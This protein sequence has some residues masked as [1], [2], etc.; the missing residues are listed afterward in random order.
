[1][2][3]VPINPMSPA[4]K[5]K[6]KP[7]KPH[8]FY[9]FTNSP[10]E[11]NPNHDKLSYFMREQLLSWIGPQ[12]SECCDVFVRFTN[13][14]ECGGVYPI[15]LDEKSTKKHKRF[16]L[17]YECESRLYFNVNNKTPEL[18]EYNINNSIIAPKTYVD[19]IIFS[20][21]NVRFSVTH[22]IHAFAQAG[23]RPCVVYWGK[24]DKDTRVIVPPYIA[25]PKW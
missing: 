22:G 24:F 21:S 8:K 17:T 13:Y 12:S 1:M 6:H 18:V 11:K 4:Q 7:H 5:N 14:S 25:H 16:R 9:K 23:D 2:S 10:Y 3:D 15:R 19:D 20:M